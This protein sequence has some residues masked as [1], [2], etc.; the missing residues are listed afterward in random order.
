MWAEYSSHKGSGG[1]AKTG[2]LGCFTIIKRNI[3]NKE[4]KRSVLSWPGRQFQA[5]NQR[6]VVDVL[7]FPPGNL[8]YTITVYEIMMGDMYLNMW[9]IFQ[10]I[11]R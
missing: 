4:G 10:W 1:V 7:D 6:R 11:N 5:W 3:I 9:G 8:E 2:C